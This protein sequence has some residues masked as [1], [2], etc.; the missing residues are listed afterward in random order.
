MDQALPHQMVKE[1][2]DEAQLPILRDCSRRHG[3]YPVDYQALVD[4]LYRGDIPEAEVVVELSS[5]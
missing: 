2:S 4:S 5:A 1:F 3:V